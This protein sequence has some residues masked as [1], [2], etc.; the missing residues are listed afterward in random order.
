MAM[1]REARRLKL[2][3]RF[4][5][6][7]TTHDRAFIAANPGMP[8][9]WCLYRDGTHIVRHDGVRVGAGVGTRTT[10]FA[11]GARLT[12]EHLRDYNL[13]MY[14]CEGDTVEPIADLERLID[15]LREREESAHV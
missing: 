14:W 6:D 5:T 4:D 12:V 2:P 13:H 7:L 9:L 3:E 10:G 1:L 15:R 8:F 11:K